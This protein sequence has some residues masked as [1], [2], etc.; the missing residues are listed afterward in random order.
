M[1]ENHAVLSARIPQG[2]E[3][4]LPSGLMSG[5]VYVSV[6]IRVFRFQFINQTIPSHVIPS[7]FLKN[8]NPPAPSK[9][10]VFQSP[11]VRRAITQKTSVCGRTPSYFAALEQIFLLTK[12]PNKK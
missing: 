1:H 3:L 5:P 9:N 6:I 10:R 12:V 8:S 2:I 7:T 4:R 11:A